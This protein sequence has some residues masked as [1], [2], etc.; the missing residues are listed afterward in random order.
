MDKNLSKF[1][2]ILLSEQIAIAAIFY[3]A[4]VFFS[5]C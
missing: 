4:Q 2:E 1:V 5:A 3:F